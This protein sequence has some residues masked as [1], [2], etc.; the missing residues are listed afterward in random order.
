MVSRLKWNKWTNNY[1]ILQQDCTVLSKVPN[2]VELKKKKKI[3]IF[4]K[5][6][7]KVCS[8]SHML[9][10]S[11]LSREPLHHVQ[12]CSVHSKRHFECTQDS[13]LLQNCADEVQ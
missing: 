2:V 4:Y 1:I 13:V 3:S 11:A 7:A 8:C 6:A 9:S 10:V 12:V 5:N